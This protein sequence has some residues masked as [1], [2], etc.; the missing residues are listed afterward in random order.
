MLDADDVAR[1]RA[2]AY[3]ADLSA[4]TVEAAIQWSKRRTSSQKL[5]LDFEEGMNY[6]DRVLAMTDDE[7]EE[8]I[9]SGRYRANLEH[10]GQ[11]VAALGVHIR[12]FAAPPADCHAGRDDRPHRPTVTIG[13][14][15]RPRDRRRRPRVAQRRAAGARAGTDPGDRDPDPA[16][17]PRLRL[18]DRIAAFYT[19]AVGLTPEQRGHE[20][21][22]VEVVAP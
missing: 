14:R 13:A 19:F 5:R 1:L 9:R 21:D 11:T 8:E 15:L 10:E 20:P 12:T 18:V 22:Q 4:E 7:L 17:R 16:P 3:V 2:T 6:D